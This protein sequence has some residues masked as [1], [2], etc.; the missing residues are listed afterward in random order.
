[1]TVLRRLFPVLAASVAAVILFAASRSTPTILDGSDPVAAELL[2]LA[3][4]LD[5]AAGPWLQLAVIVLATFLSEDLTC[6]G[7]GLLVRCGQVDLLVGLVGCYLGILVGDLG[8]WSAGRLAGIGLVRRRWLDRLL[9]PQRLNDLAAWFD[10]RGWIAVLAARF[11]P[12]TRL[13][14]YVAAGVLGRRADRFL[15]WAALAGLL[16]TPLLVLAAA[17]LGPVVVGPFLFFLGPGWPAL[18]AAVMVVFLAVR[19]AALVS[20]AQGRGQL[21]AK[22]S[23]LWRWEFWPSWLF[24]LPVLP[25]LAYLSLRYRS[26]LPWTAANP[27]IP[28]GGVVGESKFAILSQ[29]PAERVVPGFLVPSE[30]PGSR[31][32]L[33]RQELAARG[34]PFPLILKPDASQR[35]AGVKRVRDLAEVESY[36]LAQPAA[37]IVQT[38]HPGPFEAGI[39]Y[40]R[41]PGEEKGHLFSIT[42]KVFPVLVGD[43]RSTLEELIWRHPRYRMQASTFLARHAARLGQILAEGEVLP[44]AL[45]GNHCQGTMFRDGAHLFSAELERAI[46]DVARKFAGFFIGRFDVRYSDVV[47][48]R[49]GQDLAIVELNG[50]SSESTNLYDPSWS[51]FSAYRTLFRQWSL[52]YRIGHANRQRGHRPT[53]PLALLRIVL[54]HY[55]QRRI[56]PLAD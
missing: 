14:L 44:L 28:Q 8:L 7:T 36:L 22:V 30:A 3:L 50:V 37:V 29:L 10:R 26:L 33:F 1:M 47:L 48:F 40:Y 49:A 20:T 12:G 52:L 24:Y 32:D 43:G 6:I 16:W 4:R 39:F 56:E 2:P 38:Y 35:G 55:R 25:W 13:P 54:D 11:L 34:W 5:G 18:L 15:L 41:L 51:L 31:L 46:D 42:D 23:R 19:L 53:P 27:G 21:V 45:A 17:L 9:P